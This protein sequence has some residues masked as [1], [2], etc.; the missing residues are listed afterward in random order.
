M[1]KWKKRI[2]RFLA[3][4]LKDELLDIS[5]LGRMK[6]MVIPVHPNLK[7]LKVDFVIRDHEV[8]ENPRCHL[9]AKERANEVLYEEFIKYVQFDSYEILSSH[10]RCFRLL[11]K[12][13]VV[14]K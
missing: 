13:Y 1:K 12:I 14:D 11:G 10:N 4:W 8:Y 5:G 3:L 7:E 2:K 9:Q 6:P